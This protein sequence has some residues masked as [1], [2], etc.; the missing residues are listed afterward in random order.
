[1]AGDGPLKS[2]KH[3]S[4]KLKYQ[5]KINTTPPCPKLYKTIPFSC[6]LPLLW[7]DFCAIFCSLK[8]RCLHMYFLWRHICLLTNHSESCKS[9]RVTILTILVKIVTLTDLHIVLAIS[10]PDIAFESSTFEWVMFWKWQYIFIT[11]PN[12]WVVLKSQPNTAKKIIRLPGWKALFATNTAQKLINP[13]VF[14]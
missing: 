2:Q 1:M 10:L 6:H 7:L 4:P 5:L 13:I 8:S 12:P 14:E 11:V 9:V 3:F